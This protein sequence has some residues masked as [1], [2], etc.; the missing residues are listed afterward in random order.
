MPRI[1]KSN[2]HRQNFDED[3][4]RRGLIRALEKRPVSAA[5]IDSCIQRIKDNCSQS[6]IKRLSRVGLVI[7]SWAN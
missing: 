4:L 3:K 1:V 5:Q 6:P 2:G 7:M